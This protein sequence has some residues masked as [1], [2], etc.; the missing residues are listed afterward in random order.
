MREA[1][2]ALCE[3]ATESHLRKSGWGVK[4]HADAK[5]ALKQKKHLRQERLHYLLFIGPGSGPEFRGED[6]SGGKDP[7]KPLVLAF[8]CLFTLCGDCG[9][10]CF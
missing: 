10:S 6:R 2:L 7:L 9:C 3:C 8:R 5:Q 4:S 1:V